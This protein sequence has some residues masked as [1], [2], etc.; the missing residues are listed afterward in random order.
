MDSSSPLHGALLD[1]TLY[2]F[3]KRRSHEEV[4]IES[5]VSVFISCLC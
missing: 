5:V 2:L 3:D 4:L 1:E